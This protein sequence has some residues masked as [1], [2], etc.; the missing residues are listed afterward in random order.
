[1]GRL[2][3]L[4]QESLQKAGLPKNLF[5][6]TDYLR[7]FDNTA[8]RLSQQK[9][10]TRKILIRCYW[11]KLPTST[12]MIVHGRPWGHAL[13][14][15][16]RHISITDVSVQKYISPLRYFTKTNF[17]R[18]CKSQM[19]TV[20]AHKVTSLR[21]KKICYENR[22]NPAKIS[23][24]VWG[25]PCEGAITNCSEGELRLL[26]KADNERNIWA[27]IVKCTRMWD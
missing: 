10:R 5:F 3:V 6:S 9:C 18:L 20:A 24:F 1:M 14:F 2:C 26:S 27:I 17:L 8:P 22:A 21:I 15:E 7:W 19:D 25:M 16:Q 13:Y 23:V 12:G 4:L 11:D